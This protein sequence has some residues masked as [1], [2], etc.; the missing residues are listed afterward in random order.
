MPYVEVVG[1]CAHKVITRVVGY[2]E[3]GHDITKR[4]HGV[5]WAVVKNLN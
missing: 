1:H 4:F 5:L 2:I 3:E